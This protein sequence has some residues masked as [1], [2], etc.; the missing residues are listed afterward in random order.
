[1]TDNN[2][3]EHN[4]VA[5]QKRQNTDS[6]GPASKKA[7]VPGDTDVQIKILIPSGAVGAL[8]G[9]GGETMRNLKNDSGCRVQMSKN[10][11]VYRGTH[12]RI[13]LVKGKITSTMMV[14][15]AILEKIQEKI[16]EKCPS[17]Q[18][19]LKGMERSK[20]MKLVMPNTSAGLVI[21]KGGNSI[22]EI[23]ESAGASI[24]VYPKAGSEEAKISTE[25]VIT[26]GADSNSVLMDALQRVLEKVASDPLHAQQTETSSKSSDM[27]QTT[28]MSN[29]V[30]DLTNRMGSNQYSSN[31]SGYS[32]GSNPAWQSQSSLV[33]DTSFSMNKPIYNTS[34][35]PA[36]KFNPMQGLGNNELLSFL[37]SLQSTLRSSGFNESAV[38]EIMQA[39]Q[40]LAKYNIMGLGLGLGVA[41]MAQMR[42]QDMSQQPISMPPPNQPQRFDLTQGQISHHSG[43]SSLLDNN[44]GDSVISSDFV[45]Q[46][47]SYN[48]F[49]EY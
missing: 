43:L 8:I 1:M 49:Y 21:G 9:K 14:M 36:V 29:G 24:Q 32:G 12:E 20:E 41:A 34:S 30:F 11:E 16:D 45:K 28:Q 6:G 46:E 3:S 47:P 13:C 2:D 42:T 37:D 10:Q 23:R 19:D 44:S 40:I 5:G 7:H 26:I 33:S 38:S 4:V 48:A 15:Q 27:Q 25:R 18:Y 35:T 31:L 39:M 17:D 22:K